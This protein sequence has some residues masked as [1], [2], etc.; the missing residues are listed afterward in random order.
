MAFT[1]RA[2]KGVRYSEREE[3]MFS[4]LPKNGKAISSEELVK[5]FW[6]GLVS[7]PY[8]SRVSAMS[9]FRSLKQKV[10]IDNRE[11]FVIRTSLRAG[12]HPLQIWVEA[13]KVG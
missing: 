2:S 8:H 10:N 9:T 6:N 13:R 4:L 5:K 11:E 1:L 7:K 3:R 12:P